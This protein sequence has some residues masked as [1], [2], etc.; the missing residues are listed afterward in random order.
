MYKDIWK[1]SFS[2]IC[3][4]NF[5]NKS[6]IKAVTATGFKIGQYI[7]SDDYSYKHHDLSEV[8][9]FFVEKDGHT[10]KTRVVMPIQAFRDNILNGSFEES[11]GFSVI[12]GDYSEFASIPPLTLCSNAVLDIGEQAV[13]L[14]FQ[15]DHQNLCIKEGIVSAFFAENG[16]KYIEVDAT[17]RYGFSGCP[18]INLQSG[19]VIG[20][21][22][23][24]L[25]GL[26]KAY[27]QMMKII[28]EN[29][30]ALKDGVGKINIEDIDPIQVLMASQNQ[31]KHIAKEFYKT[32]DI[33]TGYALAVSH[34]LDY[35]REMAMDM[36]VSLGEISGPCK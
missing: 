16:L 18:L 4:L 32:A 8:E 36:N 2:S 21:I 25:E 34:V 1:N 26:H 14:G 17:L 3:C 7:I 24:R 6:G 33:R 23:H 5:Y 27:G 19:K 12:R 15:F 30:K 11:T 22:G 9:I 35:F 20:I 13:V 29:L 28:N 31:I 10:M